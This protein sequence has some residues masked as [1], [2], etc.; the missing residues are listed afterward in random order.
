MCV[1]ITSILI[2]LI[3]ILC[4]FIPLPFLNTSYSF[5]SLKKSMFQQMCK[6]SNILFTCKYMPSSH[7]ALRINFIPFPVVSL[8]TFI[9]GNNFTIM[10]YVHIQYEWD[11]DFLITLDHVPGQDSTS[12]LM[13]GSLLMHHLSFNS[14]WCTLKE[15]QG[16][17]TGT[18]WLTCQGS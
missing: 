8:V 16:I 4:L 9:Y 13:L 11:S 1:Y 12:L 15:D 6:A 7:N 2:I 17:H 14:E 10:V 5:M 3:S 18:E